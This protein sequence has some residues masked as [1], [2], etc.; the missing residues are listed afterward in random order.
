MATSRSSERSRKIPT[1]TSGPTPSPRRWR[2]SRPARRSQLAVGRG[3]SPPIHHRHG[4][5]PAGGLRRDQLV[6]AR[7]AAGAAAAA[8][9]RR[10]AAARSAGVSRGSLREAGLRRRDGA[11]EQRRADAP[12]RRSAV[13][14]SNRSRLYSRCAGEPSAPSARKRVRSNLAVSRRDLHRARPSRPGSSRRARDGASL[15]RQHHLEERV[16][17]EARARGASSSTSRSNGRSWWA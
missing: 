12:S 6:D 3:R 17:P 1:G 7:T 5:R 14:G 16:A 10:R 13:A 8:G 15:Q 9:S 11:A 2:A 4:L